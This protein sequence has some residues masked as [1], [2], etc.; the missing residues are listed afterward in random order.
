MRILEL[1]II[2]V[3]DLTEGL[4]HSRYLMSGDSYFFFFLLQVI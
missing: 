3:E 1:E 4:A 2:Y